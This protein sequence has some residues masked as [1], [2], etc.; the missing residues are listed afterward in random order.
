MFALHTEG[1]EGGNMKDESIEIVEIG[2]EKFKV[3]FEVAALLQAVSD[4]RDAALDWLS[5]RGTHGAEC[6][7][8]YECRCGLTAL[9]GNP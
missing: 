2:G 4:E 8:G 5:M 7:P 1:G 6:T 9:I 3:R